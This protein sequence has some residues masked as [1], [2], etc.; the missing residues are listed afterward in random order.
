MVV[1]VLNLVMESS[2]RVQGRVN[3]RRGDGGGRGFL[4]VRK[5]KIVDLIKTETLMIFVL[6]G[7]IREHK[8]YRTSCNKNTIIRYDNGHGINQI[9]KIHTIR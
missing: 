7:H 2:G 8:L 6:V 4:F 9:K 1:Q 5:L 3:T